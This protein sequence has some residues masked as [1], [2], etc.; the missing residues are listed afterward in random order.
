MARAKNFLGVKNQLFPAPCEGIF[1]KS[2]HTEALFSQ[3]FIYT[4]FE[5]LFLGFAK[6]F[7]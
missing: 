5:Q 3:M 4:N 7:F 2:V 6:F 1:E